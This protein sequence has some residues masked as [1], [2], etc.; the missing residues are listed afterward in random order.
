V[1]KVSGFTFVHNGVAGGYPFV[2]AIHAVLA[3]VDEVVVVDM[4]STD[5]TRKVLDQLDVR[6]I[7]GV[8]TPGAAGH[9]L[10][11]NHA[12]HHKCEHDLILHFEADEVYDP[13]VSSAIHRAIYDGKEQISVYRLQVEQNFQRIRWYPELV[14]RVFPKNSVVKDGHTTDYAQRGEPTYVLPQTYGYLWDVTNCFRDEWVSRNT[15]QAEL[16]GN[17]PKHRYTSYHAAQGFM[18]CENAESVRELLS[19]PHWTW[20]ETPLDLPMN[21]EL[22]IGYTSYRDRLKLLGL[23]E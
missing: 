12:L 1:R 8:W 10:K 19:Q 22:L 13:H 3:D 15:Q 6:V 21:L 16:W 17:E 11:W 4:Q 14:H 2:E 9:C 18:T 23:L 20:T 5:E 7:D